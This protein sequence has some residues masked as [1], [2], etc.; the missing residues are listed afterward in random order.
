MY[1]PV[2]SLLLAVY[3]AYLLT[4]IVREDDLCGKIRNKD[5]IAG[6]KAVLA[7]AACFLAASVAGL[8]LG[9]KGVLVEPFL[10]YSYYAALAANAVIGLAAGVV[11]WKTEVWPAGDAKLFA[12][13]CAALPL[14]IPYAWWSP[15]ALFL[16]L[17]V[18]IF[19]PAAVVYFVQM[20]D[21]QLD[22]LLSGGAR[23]AWAKLSGK[24][25]GL[26]REPGKIGLFLFTMLLFSFVGVWNSAQTGVFKINDALFF[27]LLLALGG[28]I[29]GYLH[30]AGPKFVLLCLA[31]AAVCAALSPAFMGLGKLVLYSLVKSVQFT[32]FRGVLFM[33]A[34]RH[35]ATAGTYRIALAE[36][37][38]GMIV[39][40]EYLEQLRGSAPEF[41]EGWS[42]DKYRDGLTAEQAAGLAGFLKNKDK[43]SGEELAIPV[44]RVRPFAFWIAL[45][46]ALTAALS[47]RNILMMAQYWLAL[48]WR[49]VTA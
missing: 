9:A 37:R 24:A 31:A 23:A 4:G 11:L 1:L 38:P 42:P 39:S 33:V 44:F 41:M 6:A 5:L 17:L 8:E 27:V 36:L 48:A 21:D 25:A 22:R 26:L 3:L 15:R 46:T 47:G 13:V 16:T 32:V 12:L 20:S 30:K 14:L 2:V 43:G 34:E 19:T 10:G 29:G 35:Q 28:R 7:A 49:A 18:N 40:E 45:G